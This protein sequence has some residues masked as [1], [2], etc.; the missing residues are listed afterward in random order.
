MHLQLHVFELLRGD[1]SIRTVGRTVLNEHRAIPVW[2]AVA[3]KY[4]YTL[5][6]RLRRLSISQLYRRPDRDELRS[7]PRPNIVALEH[8]AEIS[9]LLAVMCDRL[10]RI[11]AAN[12]GLNR[13]IRA[14]LLNE[15]VLFDHHDAIRFVHKT[16]RLGIQNSE[17]NTV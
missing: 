13:G 7:H 2:I 6:K 12:L 14:E 1:C 8:H 11:L 9:H 15:L 3:S 4:Q 16:P 10:L 17:A 5:F